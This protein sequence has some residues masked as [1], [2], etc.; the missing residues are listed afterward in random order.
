MIFTRTK[1]NNYGVTV[2]TA[3]G[4]RAGILLPKS[5][6]GDAGAPETIELTAEN[7]ATPGAVKTVA[8]TDEQKAKAV[9]ASE[10]AAARAAKAVERAQKAQA[11]L[12]KLGIGT[13]PAASEAP[14]EETVQ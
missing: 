5:L 13:A 9:A 8:S 10:K 3:P 11:R 12:A 2:Y 7:L 1:T 14:V 6:F 4:M